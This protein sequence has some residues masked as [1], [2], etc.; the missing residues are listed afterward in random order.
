MTKNPKIIA[1]IAGLAILLGG[2]IFMLTQ[3][4]PMSADVQLEMSL[5]PTP[6][7]PAPDTI[8]ADS[9]PEIAEGDWGLEV[10]DMQ[11]RLLELGYFTD[12]VDGQFGPITKEAVIAFQAANHLPA[13]GVIDQ[14]TREVLLSQSAIPKQ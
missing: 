3:V 2:L 10:E 7:P 4:I 11:R 14:K 12:S 13:N 8:R 6:L 9:R 1:G 5:T